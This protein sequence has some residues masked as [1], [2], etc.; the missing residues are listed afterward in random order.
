MIKKKQL[1]NAIFGISIEVF[2]ALCII[3]AAFLG[4]F[5]INLKK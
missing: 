5:L 4:A 2:Y 3:F 1:L